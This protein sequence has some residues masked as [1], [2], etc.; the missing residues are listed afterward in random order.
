[1]QEKPDPIDTEMQ[2]RLDTGVAMTT[3]LHWA[4]DQWDKA[5]NRAYQIALTSL[6]ARE[7][8][9]LKASQ[10]SWLEFRDREFALMT[11]LV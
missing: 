5:M 8:A 3:T 1:M 10:R 4:E 9:L 6:P 11:R 2:K 7:K